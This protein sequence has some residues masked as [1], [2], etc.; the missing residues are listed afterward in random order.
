MYSQ[1]SKRYK[2]GMSIIW[3]K[4]I[5]QEKILFSKLFLL[6]RTNLWESNFNSA[7]TFISTNVWNWLVL[8]RPVKEYKMLLAG[9]GRTTMF[10][11][12]CW[13]PDQ[14]SPILPISRYVKYF[15]SIAEK[16]KFWSG[17]KSYNELPL[18]FLKL[19]RQTIKH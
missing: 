1:S 10:N 15:W 16:P 4:I 18:K 8:L 5:L 19:L 3:T 7:E 6:E 14:H 2:R 13:Q 17:N 11:L 9:L 12:P